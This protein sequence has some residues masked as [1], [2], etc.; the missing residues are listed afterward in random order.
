MKVRGE[1]LKKR[2]ER[3]FVVSFYKSKE[4][5]DNFTQN[6]RSYNISFGKESYL[7]D[8]KERRFESD[9]YNMKIER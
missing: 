8:I 3:S 2:E 9:S 4:P 7:M 6:K 5:C 1:L